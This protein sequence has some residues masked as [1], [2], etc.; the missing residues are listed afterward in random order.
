[1]KKLA[2]LLVF[3]FLV[4]TAAAQQVADTSYRFDNPSPAYDAG[5]GP[6][7]CIDGAHF[8]FHTEEGRYKPFAELLRGDGYRVKGVGAAFA[9]DTLSECQI[10]VIANAVSERNST[11]R[12]PPHDSAFSKQEI[13]ALLAW[14]RDGGAFLLIVDHAPYPGAASD[15]AGLLGIHML[16]AFASSSKEA[17]GALVVFGAPDIV[18][19]TKWQQFV[20]AM[21][22]TEEHLRRILSHPG[23]LA[24]HPIVEGRSPRERITSV[25]TFQGQAFYP[26]SRIEPIL[27][28]GSR[29][30]A[31]IPLGREFKPEEYPLFSVSGWLQGGASRLGKG[32]VVIL[33]EA[34]MCTAQVAG[35][36]RL[37]AGINAPVAAQ[38]A[39]FCLNVLHWLSGLLDKK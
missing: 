19:E 33:G 17:P 24:Q 8:N 32:R 27:V 6:Q 2:S 11:D 5:T 31:M 21:G 22:F 20:K 16:D 7:V 25:V 23:T 12:S 30:A 4:A 10:L 34:A 35:P 1:M 37:P 14:I 28:F 38:N 9:L 29:A 18:D 13:E 15:L 36:Q 39:Q 3:G 26:S